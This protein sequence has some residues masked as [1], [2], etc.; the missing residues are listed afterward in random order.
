MAIEASLETWVWLAGG[1]MGGFWVVAALLFA[2]G[3][4]GDALNTTRKGE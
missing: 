3:F 1:I 4:V 2:A